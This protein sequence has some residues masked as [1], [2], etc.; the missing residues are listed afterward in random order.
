MNSEEV[1]KASSKLAERLTK[2]S[3]GDLKSAVALGYRTAVRLMTSKSP[4][5]HFVSDG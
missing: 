5:T 4:I 1:D 2:E 3:G